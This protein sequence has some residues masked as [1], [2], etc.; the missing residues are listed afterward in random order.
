MYSTAFLIVLGAFFLQY[1]RSGKAKFG[2][3]PRLLAYLGRHRWGS[4]ALSLVLTV[5]AMVV[6]ITR[7]GVGSGVFAFVVVL[8]AAASL[9]V[10]LAPL[11]L[12]QVVQV[13]VLYGLMVSLEVV[14]F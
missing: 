2:Q 1:N 14:V 10:S 3:R 7:L 5:A 13:M 9:T 8:M 4:H 12:I 11:R 6:L